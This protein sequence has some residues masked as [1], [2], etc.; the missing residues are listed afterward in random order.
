MVEMITSAVIAFIFFV[1]G[2]RIGQQEKP[3]VKAEDKQDPASIFRTKKGLL[4][5]KKYLR[6]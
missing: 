3:Q 1:A 6:D 2:Y 5:Y 4:S